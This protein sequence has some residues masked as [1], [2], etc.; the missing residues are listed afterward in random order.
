MSAHSQCGGCITEVCCPTV[1]KQMWQ[2]SLFGLAQAPKTAPGCP[3]E[4]EQCRNVPFLPGAATHESE[5]AGKAVRPTVN[6]SDEAQEHVQQQRH[7]NLPS[8][9]VGALAQKVRQ[10]QSLLD[11]FEEHFNLPAAAVEVGNRAR[12][13]LQVVSQKD[14]L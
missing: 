9:C 12:T 2:I 3:I 7:P 1:S 13:P 8:H 10:L 4:F 14:H 5:Q 11:L 6:P